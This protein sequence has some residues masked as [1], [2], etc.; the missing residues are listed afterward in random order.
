M[1]SKKGGAYSREDTVIDSICTQ[2]IRD[3]R[4]QEIS[5]MQEILPFFKKVQEI[6]PSR[7]V[8]IMLEFGSKHAQNAPFLHQKCKKVWGGEGGIPPDTRILVLE[9]FCREFL[10]MPLRSL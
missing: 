8:D 3:R 4:V 1:E 10:S 2:F 5:G 9:E 6:L 7:K